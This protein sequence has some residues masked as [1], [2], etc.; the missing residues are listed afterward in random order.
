MVQK[1]TGM[2]LVQAPGWKTELFKLIFKSSK[3]HNFQRSIFLS[4]V[5]KLILKLV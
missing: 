5:A 3:H 2:F 4:K 1:F